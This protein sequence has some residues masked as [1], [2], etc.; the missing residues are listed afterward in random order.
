MFKVFC[1]IIKMGT[2][3]TTIFFINCSYIDNWEYIHSSIKNYLNEEDIDYSNIIITNYNIRNKFIIN[4]TY[5][6]I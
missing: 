6:I 1:Q 3:F 2:Q 4:V 5:E